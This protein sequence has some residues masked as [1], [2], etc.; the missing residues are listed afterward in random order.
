MRLETE[1]THAHT[2][3]AHPHCPK[4]SLLKLGAGSFKTLAFQEEIDGSD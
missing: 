2:K 3:N 4:Q 1:L